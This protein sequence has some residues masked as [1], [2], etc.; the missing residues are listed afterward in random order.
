MALLM[1]L[2]SRKSGGM[3]KCSRNEV[4]SRLRG[5]EGKERE[6]NVKEGIKRRWEGWLRDL[7]ERMRRM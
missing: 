5:D 4:G 2:I 7:V 6:K 1:V 3:G